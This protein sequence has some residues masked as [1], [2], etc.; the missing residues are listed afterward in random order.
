MKKQT[1]TSW[2]KV[3][4]WYGSIVKGK[5]HYYH[6]RVI[7]PK[8]KQILNFNPKHPL[9]VLDLG[10]GE[11]VFSRILPPSFSYTGVDYSPSLIKL[12]K[13]QS[14]SSHFKFITADVTQPLKLPK[15]TFDL[16]IFILSLQDMEKGDAA[17]KNAANYLKSGGT[18]ALVLNHPC[19]RIPKQTHWE[20]DEENH[21]QY[22][23]VN[24]YL[25]TEKIPIQTEPSKGEKSKKVFSF[26]RSLST[27]FSW[28]SRNRLA[29]TDLEEWVSDKKSTGS[30]AKMENFARKEFPLF[31]ALFAVKLPQAD[32]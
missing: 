5:G 11:G 10:C 7:L 21:I 18:L 23:R 14:K 13:S 31:L 20:V 8:L 24:R 32:V 3:S 15:E 12:A 26:H 27:Y 19:F 29:V 1:S 30:K 17:I 9:N 6:K 25:S 16:V 2:E 22:R 28:L 4:S